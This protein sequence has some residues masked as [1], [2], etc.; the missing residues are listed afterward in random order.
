MIYHAKD[1]PT[2]EKLDEFV[3]AQ[4]AEDDE[5]IVG[6]EDELGEKSLS[7]NSIVYGVPCQII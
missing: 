3:R 6:T 4:P 1:Y 7:L 5:V 2:R